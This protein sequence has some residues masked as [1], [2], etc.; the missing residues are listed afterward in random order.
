MA[1]NTLLKNFSEDIKNTFQARKSITDVAAKYLSDLSEESFGVTPEQMEA[2]TGD[3]DD[4][5]TTAD[6]NLVAAINEV[7]ANTGDLSDLTT[8][9]K[10]NL[11]GAINEIDA[12]V[13]KGSVSVT[14]DGTKTYTQLF[15]TLYGLMDQSKINHHSK[16][17]IS[18]ADGSKN[19][20]YLASI[21]TAGVY[22]F[23]STQIIA[24]GSAWYLNTL[25]IRN[26][27]SA[28]RYSVNG[29]T[30]T[31]SVTPA[32]ETEIKLYY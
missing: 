8:T 1:I 25:V 4:L 21:N 29:A 6:T 17:V 9:E 14:A 10:T 12:E 22:L 20:Y 2:V 11:V 19:V 31:T 15:D 32:N 13:N 7:N 27:S 30:P 28:Y 24:D 5:T 16:I 23:S 18:N 3:L 26:A